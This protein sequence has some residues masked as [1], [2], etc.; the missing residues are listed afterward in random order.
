MV[1]PASAAKLCFPDRPRRAL[2]RHPPGALLVSFQLNIPNREHPREGML[3]GTGRAVAVAD[4]GHDALAV[5]AMLW[6]VG[7][8]EE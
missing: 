4:M 8:G 7:V 6:V 3:A 2:P 5:R 1:L